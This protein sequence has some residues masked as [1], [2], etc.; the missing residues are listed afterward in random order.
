MGGGGGGAN[1]VLPLKIGGQKSFN[2][3]KGGGQKSF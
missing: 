2:L 1:E 3:K